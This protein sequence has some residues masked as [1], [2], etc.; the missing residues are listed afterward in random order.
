MV[1]LEGGD[2]K[3]LNL[4][5]SQPRYVP[6]GHIVYGVDG[7]LR[8]VGFDLDR[9]DVFGNP[10]AVQEGV[11]TKGSGAVN[12]G[13]SDTGALL[14]VGGG[15][16]RT[17]VWVDRDGRE[18]PLLGHSPANLYWGRL[19]PDGMRVAVNVSENGNQDIWVYD[20]SPATQ[21]RL[22]FHPADETNQLWTP[23]GERVAFW[24]AR[25][26]EPGLYWKLADG[27]DP[28]ER[29]LAPS[30]GVRRI[31]P[32][33]WSADGKALAY[34]QFRPGA[35]TNIDLLSLEGDPQAQL[36]IATPFRENSP[37]I[38][39]NG[40]WLAY[41]SWETGEPQVYVQRF[42]ELGGR[43]AVS[44]ESGQEPVWSRDGRELFY[45][46]RRGMMVVSVE[47]EPMFRAGDPELLFKDQQFFQLRQSR[48]YDVASDGRFLMTKDPVAQIILV[49]NWTDELQRLVP[50]P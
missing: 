49:Q 35:E 24:S 23:D 9:L 11:N 28:P 47:F 32:S 6:T 34:W 19:S 48:T 10:V 36:L 29:L 50:T 33:A 15:S 38:S 40:D 31:L 45:R 2:P 46:G 41:T 7:T 21:T 42:P 12:F 14:Y 43:V 20:V 8:A 17:L 27:S 22:T 25:E 1:S 18:A 39:P 3:V 37:A 30:E 5:G 44:T 16:Q 13:V 4:R 26:D